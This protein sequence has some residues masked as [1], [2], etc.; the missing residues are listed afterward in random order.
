MVLVAPYVLI[1]ASSFSTRSATGSGWRA[2]RPATSSWS[3]TRSSLRSVV[4][5]LVFLVV[6]IN[7]KMV[8]ALF[9][10]GFFVQRADVD[11][12]AVAALHPAVGGAVDPDHPVAPLHAQP[13]VG[14]H[15]HDDLPAH[16][17][18]RAELAQQPDARA[19]PGDPRPHLEVA[20][21]L[22]A[23]PGRRPA[24]DSRRDVRGGL[25]RRRHRAGR[26][27]SSSPGRRCARST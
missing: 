25:G 2:I 14:H 1:F 9:L 8:V 19:R 3:T 12:V 16:R 20:A 18:R 26:S 4:N 13:R 15:Q 23:D 11:Q 7:L 24:R 27:S 5:T 21:V 6:G 10:S 22:D 17:R